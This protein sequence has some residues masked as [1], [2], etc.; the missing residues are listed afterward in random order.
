MIIQNKLQ[1]RKYKLFSLKRL[2]KNGRIINSVIL[3]TINNM[4]NNVILFL[5]PDNADLEDSKES[6][7]TA[8]KVLP[9]LLVLGYSF[10]FLLGAG[11]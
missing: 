10:L 3:K 9:V 6:F 8:F 2:V 11:A 7:K 5:S 1:V 4:V